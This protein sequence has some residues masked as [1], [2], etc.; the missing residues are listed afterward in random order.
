LSES[1]LSA[2][3]ERLERRSPEAHIELG[4]ERVATVRAVLG[5]KPFGGPVISVAG[6]NGKG[7]TVAFLEAIARESGYR[8]LA[9]TS[10][11]LLVFGERIRI[12]GKPAPA[13]AIV[14]ALERVEQAR[15]ETYL[16][17]FEHITLAALAVA[18]AA[19]PDL[20]ILEVGLGGRLDAVNVVDADVAIVTSIG[21]DHT[22]WLGRTRLK[23]AREKVGIA[24]RGRPLI[25]GEKRRPAGLDDYLAG[26][27]IKP[28]RAGREIRWRRSG[29]DWMLVTPQTRRSLPPP[30][31]DGEF[32]YANAACALAALDC[33]AARLPVSD[34]AIAYGLKSARLF[35]RLQQ[36]AS[37][38]EILLDVAHNPAAARALARSLGRPARR[39][40]AVFAALADKDASA[41]ARALDGSFDHWILA[42]LTGFRGQSA[43]ALAER[44]G[45][46]SVAGSVE[47]VESVSA[48]LARA[49]IRSGPDGRVVVFGSFRTVAEAWSALEKQ[50]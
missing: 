45:A 31:L 48:A 33:L 20:M 28:L 21:L 14:A 40:V 5:L 7:S 39:Q 23:I 32:Q 34:E 42:G 35:G 12:D 29:K 37:A 9:Y 10:P 26:Q 25:I 47:T 38:P 2:W 49:R 15:G 13:D 22:D 17:Y 6:T 4:L 36:V 1:E 44:V 41:I 11:H 43:A 30:G 50:K 27:G 24:R 3:L 46:V 8:T 16:T 19:A 18:E